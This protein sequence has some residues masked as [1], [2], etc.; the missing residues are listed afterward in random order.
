MKIKVR[1]HSVLGGQTLGKLTFASLQMLPD[2]V[3][4]Y[5]N[6]ILYQ[7]YSAFGQTDQWYPLEARKEGDVVTGKLRLETH[8]RK[9]FTYVP[10]SS[11]EVPL[12]RMRSKEDGNRSLE[13]H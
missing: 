4:P 11:G 7:T 6:V 1:N 5:L 9:V 8:F 13:K 10:D 2:K 12:T 3:S